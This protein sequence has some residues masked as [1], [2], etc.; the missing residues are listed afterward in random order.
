MKQIKKLFFLVL[1]LSQQ[2]SFASISSEEK[3]V[4]R[5]DFF[6][7]ISHI[8]YDEKKTD[9]GFDDFK[10]DIYSLYVCDKDN[11]CYEYYISSGVPTVISV[12]NINTSNMHEVTAMLSYNKLKKMY[13]TGNLSTLKL[14]SSKYIEDL[15]PIAL[16][17]SNNGKIEGIEITTKQSK[18]YSYT[19]SSVFIEDPEKAKE[20]AILLN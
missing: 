17:T 15:P 14:I 11:L 2:F 5:K 3:K 10:V 7:N 1:I 20:W 16:L 18:D 6:N 8:Y 13:F 9:N 4:L 19:Y 12:R